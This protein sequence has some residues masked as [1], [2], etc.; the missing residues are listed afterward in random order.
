MGLVEVLNCGLLFYK[1]ISLSWK[2]VSEQGGNILGYLRLRVRGL[3][4]SSTENNKWS[5]GSFLY[6]IIQ[7]FSIP[8]LHIHIS[9]P[10]DW[11]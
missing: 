7:W 6:D 4:A 9:K 8:S 3:E 11:K 2:T 10:E 5:Q 1:F